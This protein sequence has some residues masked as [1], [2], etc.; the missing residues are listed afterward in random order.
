MKKMVE[1]EGFLVI[2]MMGFDKVGSFFTK[3]VEEVSGIKPK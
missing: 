3:E 2:F 1:N